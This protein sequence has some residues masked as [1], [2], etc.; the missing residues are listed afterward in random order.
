VHVPVALAS[1]EAPVGNSARREE[2]GRRQAGDASGEPIL[3]GA[4]WGP[5][6]QAATVEGAVRA[7]AG[8]AVEEARAEEAVRA[9]GVAEEAQAEEAAV[10]SFAPA[11]SSSS[12][13]CKSA[14]PPRRRTA[15]A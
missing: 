12:S 3:A 9:A 10:A 13:P 2:D 15:P 4:C 6:E 14:A 7:A 8:V 11:W 5:R 1:K